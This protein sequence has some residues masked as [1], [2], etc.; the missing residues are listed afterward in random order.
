MS[1][2]SRDARSDLRRSRALCAI[3]RAC[4]VALLPALAMSEVQAAAECEPF[5]WMP[6]R[7]D[8]NAAKDR[9]RVSSIESFHFDANVESLTRGKTGVRSAATSTFWCA[10][11]R[12][13][14]GGWLRWSGWR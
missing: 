12:I 7:L 3:A 5:V 11:S 6:E 10:T 2:V 14:I 9:R 1:T 4:V 8:F 13:I